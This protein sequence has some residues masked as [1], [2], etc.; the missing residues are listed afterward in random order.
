MAGGEFLP[1]CHVYGP[2]TGDYLQ[3]ILVRRGSCTRG[4]NGV[5][6]YLQGEQD[7]YHNFQT[8]MGDSDGCDATF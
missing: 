4:L 7:L 5:L 3:G 8:L 6:I 2:S 1:T